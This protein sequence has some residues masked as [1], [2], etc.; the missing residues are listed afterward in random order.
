[1]FK[2][3]IS[4]TK[5]LIETFNALKEINEQVNLKLSKDGISV[6]SMDDSH[7]SLC[8]LHIDETEFD[9][10]TCDKMYVI[11]VS[12]K[13]FVEIL[14]FNNNEVLTI[15]Y[16]ED[17]DI[18]SLDYESSNYELKLLTLD[19]EDLHVPDSMDYLCL[20]VY[21]SSTFNKNITKYLTMDMNVML[22]NDIPKKLI[23]FKIRGSIVNCDDKPVPIK[24]EMKKVSFKVP[25][26]LGILSKISKGFF[27]SDNVTLYISDDQ[28]LLI[29][30]KSNKSFIKYYLAP[31]LEE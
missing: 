28:P 19:I 4:K 13:Q 27:M 18:V 25:F 23:I 26:A 6:Q 14:K 20:V 3:T 30:Y 8:V 12:L 1:M 5:F 11:G 21:N 24:I 7:I 2:A 22:E 9:N 16:K 29:E 17:S 10:I 15:V 31:K